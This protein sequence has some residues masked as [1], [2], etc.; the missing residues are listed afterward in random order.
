MHCEKNY[1]DMSCFISSEFS[2]KKLESM[3][4]A[5]PFEPSCEVQ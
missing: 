5:S 4:M 3:A 1:L 2:R